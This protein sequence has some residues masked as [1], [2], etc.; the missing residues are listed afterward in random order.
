LSDVSSEESISTFIETR[1][2]DLAVPD[3]EVNSPMPCTLNSFA[4]CFVSKSSV[5]IP[6]PCKLANHLPSLFTK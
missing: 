5:V 6:A 4:A 1:K 2:P 3:D